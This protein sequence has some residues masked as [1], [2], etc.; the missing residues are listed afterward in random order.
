MTSA[1]NGCG[2]NQI[3][4]LLESPVQSRREFR[5]GAAGGQIGM[6]VPAGTLSCLHGTLCGPPIE[7]QKADHANGR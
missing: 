3:A 1:M 6:I 5:S 4:A 7:Y 2:L